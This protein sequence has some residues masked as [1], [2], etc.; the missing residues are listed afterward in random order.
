MASLNGLK[1]NAEPLKSYLIIIMAIAIVVLLAVLLVDSCAA[2]PPPGASTQ[3]EANFRLLLSDEANAIAD[4][5][6]LNVVISKVGVHEASGN[7]TWHEFDID[8]AADPDN[9][10]VP[11]VNLRA[12]EGENALEIWSANLSA[13]EYT[14]VFIYIESINGSLV[15]G[16]AADVKLP[17]DRLQISHPFTINDS[18]VNFVYDI[19]VHRAGGSGKYILQPQIAQS[20]VNQSFNDVTPEE[21]EF[22]GTILTINGSDWTMDID[23]ETWAV[24]VSAAAISGEPAEGA[25]AKVTGIAEDG[26]ITASKVV[27]QGAETPE[28]SETPEETEVPEETETPETTETP[29]ETEAPEATETPSATETPGT[30]ETP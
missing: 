13:G 27:I 6:A 17:G 3:G 11:G 9:D 2:T 24:N 10:G 14:K 26:T 5:A 23:G 28:A 8:A 29:E 16:E 18:I 7:G 21:T 20:G 22:T 15:G 19:A 25:T 1:R 4:F 30:T 12:L